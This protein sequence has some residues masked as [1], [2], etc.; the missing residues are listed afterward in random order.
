MAASPVLVRIAACIAAS[1]RAGCRPNRL[2]ASPLLLR[3]RD[4]GEQLLTTPPHRTQPTEHRTVT[5]PGPGEALVRALD[6][7]LLGAGRRPHPRV[8][9]GENI[10]RLRTHGIRAQHTTGMPHPAPVLLL[11][12]P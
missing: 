11:V 6:G 3:Q 8:E 9:T 1:S 2:A 4:L 10:P 7:H 5:E 12:R